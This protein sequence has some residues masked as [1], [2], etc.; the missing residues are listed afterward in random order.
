M[1]LAAYALVITD[2]VHRTI[3]AL[4]A[5]FLIVALGV[6]DQHT[7][8]AHVDF[9]VI[10]LL[11]GM[12]VIAG[13]IGRSGFFQWMAAGTVRA[14]GGDPYRLLVALSVISASLS[15][16]LDN[17]TAVVLL[18]PIAFSV[19][20]RRGMPPL[21]LLISIVLAS[22]IGGT[23]TLIGDPPNIII[24]SAFDKD[25][26]TF[27]AHTGP[28]A[29]VSLVAYLGL[30]RWL[31]R[32][33]L[34]APVLSAEAL[35]ALGAFDQSMLDR[36]LA[37]RSLAVLGAT[38]VGF[39]LARPLGLEGATIALLGA[40]IV[41][42]ITR[43][44]VHSILA[45]VEWPTLLFFVGLFVLVG[46]LVETGVIA[47]M[48]EATLRLTAG[49]PRATAFVVLWL[50]AVL[51][52]VIDNI[53]YT[54]TMVPLLQ[55]IGRHGVTIEPSIW[56]LALGADLGGNATLIGASAN[57]V[58]ASMS[59]ARGRPISFAQFFRYGMPVALMTMLV[60]S[61]DLFIRY[62]LL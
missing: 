18:A 47:Q 36:P 37:F 38:L 45:E 24:G 10:L 62:V 16:V 17:V 14:T 40:S 8:L 60:A 9:N 35:R 53:P 1:L 7:A 20:E 58:V 42:L 59:E 31:F 57:V 23:A 28:A 41:L 22:N 6:L 11:V 34:L 33:E 26:V 49:D 46:G 15:A 32:N 50:S 12:M 19:A 54:A 48:A 56:A 43:V 55:E 44:E 39:L 5:G 4:F 13:V 30:A 51:S 3:V 21:P 52:A 25:F 29:L 61:L 2:M 27:L